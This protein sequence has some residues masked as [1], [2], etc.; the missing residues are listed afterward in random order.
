M[1]YEVNPLELQ[2]KL[3]TLYQ[4]YLS[5]DP[6]ERKEARRLAAEYDG[7][8][9]GDFLLGEALQEAIRSLRYVYMKPYL[10]KEK[11]RDIIQR[12]QRKGEEDTDGS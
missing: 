10:S 2:K 11:A 6:Q 7:F 1:V 5:E 3:L 4:M 12:L 8:W 9:S